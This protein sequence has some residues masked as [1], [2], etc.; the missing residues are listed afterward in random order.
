MR[1]ART[2]W[3]L[4]AL[5]A[6]GAGAGAA[7]Q[8]QTPPPPPTPRPFPGAVPPT[9]GTTKPADPNATA[10]APQPPPTPADLGAA[11]IYPSAEFLES[12]DLGGG[13][14][15][16]IYGTNVAYDQIVTYYRA[17]RLN[18]R[19]LFREPPMQQF[20]LGRYDEKLMAQPPA[21]VVKDYTWNGSQGYLH[22]SGTAEKRYRTIIQ[23]VP[24]T[25]RD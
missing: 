25:T 23:I 24:A 15:M 12:Y 17:Q 18:G 6:F 2:A 19:E 5:V 9:T 16:L 11:M 10:P 22:V 13:Q 21:I 7:Q 14:K 1:R 4:G 20:D 8:T 3:I